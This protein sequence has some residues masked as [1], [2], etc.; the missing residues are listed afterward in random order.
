[1]KKLLV[2]AVG[3]LVGAWAMNQF[4]DYVARRPRQGA[5]ARR[6]T[7]GEPATLKAAETI[8]DK[9]LHHDPSV[10]EKKLAEPAMHYLFGVF[11]GAIYA[12]ST[13]FIPVGTRYWSLLFSTVLWLTADEIVV[14]I[15]GLS[16]PPW[17]YPLP[18]HLKALVSHWVYGLG[19]E[20]TRRIAA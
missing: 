5:S 18:T 10:N 16:A 13:D 14:P 6:G 17:D 9:L 11:S 19:A 3:G 15:L 2:G 20:G 12:L 8:S 4:Q 7:G 1:M